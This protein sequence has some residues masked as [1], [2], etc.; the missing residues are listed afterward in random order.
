[1]KSLEDVFSQGIPLG[2][3]ASFLMRLRGTD[4]TASVADLEAAVAALPEDERVEIQKMAEGMGMTLPSAAQG[5]VMKP[6]PAPALPPT[7]MGQNSKVA[8]DRQ[9]DAIGR[10]RGRA[11]TSA[12]FERQSHRSSEKNRE[13]AGRLGGAAAG[14]AAAH[15]GGK[16]NP[17]STLVGVAL[18]SHLGGRVGK[19]S[20]QVADAKKWESEKK[21]FDA[22]LEEAGLAPQPSAQKPPPVN[23]PPP[24][25]VEP[26]IDPQ[27]QAYLQQE[28]AADAEAETAHI[29]MLREKLQQAQA[30]LQESKTVSDTLQQTQAQHDATLQQMQQQVAESF[31]QAAGAQDEVLKNQQAAAAMRMAFQQLRG[32]VLELAAS[33]PPTLSPDAQALMA[34]AAAPPTAGA[35]TPQQGP[36]NQAG[37]PGA[38]PGAAPPAGDEAVNQNASSTS[39]DPVG[40]SSPSGQTGQKDQPSSGGDNKGS[41]SSGSKVS[42]KIGAAAFAEVMKE[43]SLGDFIAQHGYAAA[44]RLPHAAAGAALGAGLGAGESFT[45]NEPLK[46]RIQ[47]LEGKKERGLRDTLDLAQLRARHTVG[48]FAQEHP[49]AMMG[50]GALGGALLGAQ[51]GPSLVDA[52]KQSVQQGGDIAKKIKI[53][54][55]GAV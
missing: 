36:A 10:S 24:A 27:T 19:R 45:S 12:H 30:E 1:M 50:A 44:A 54:I 7:A 32:K 21:A 22:A 17:L 37:S 29:G 14:G 51:H 16:K 5:Q 9:D 25:A 6:A 20:G 4:K 55:Q 8:N 53:M 31:Q 3:A 11:A 42:L 28:Q 15:F 41:E 26:Q 38:A 34:A 40:E 18:G 23:T 2:E 39:S 49:G 35:P 48:E 46:Q 33:D 43:A 13:L 52:A 47:G